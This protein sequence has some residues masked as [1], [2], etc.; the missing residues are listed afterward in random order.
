MDNERGQMHAMLHDLHNITNPHTYL[1]TYLEDIS[2]AFNVGLIHLNLPI[3]TA[4]A[5]QGLV[6]DIHSV[7]R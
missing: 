3:E 6:Q 1:P 4:G 2:S 7:G 5:G